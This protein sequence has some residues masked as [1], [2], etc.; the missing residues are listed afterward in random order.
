METMVITATSAAI[1]MIFT[2]APKATTNDAKPGD[3]LKNV[4]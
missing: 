1:G 4:K 2:Q 3:S